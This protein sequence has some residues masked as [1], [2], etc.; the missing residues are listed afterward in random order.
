MTER[1]INDLKELQALPLNI[2]VAM[3]CSRIRSWVN[4]FG[5]DGV[6]ISFSGG[7]DSTVLMDLVRNVCGYK[8]RAMFVDVPTQYPELKEFVKTFPDVDIVKPK[9]SF[10]EVCKKYGF[11]LVSKEVSQVVEEARKAKQKGKL[12]EER[13]QKL[14]GEYIDPKTGELSPY[15]CPKWKFLLDA[16]FDVST[17]CCAAMKKEPAHRYTKETGRKRMTAMM[18]EES[19][20]RTSAWIKQGCNAFDANEPS[21]MPMAFWTENDVLEYIYTNKLPICSVY[22]EVIPKGGQLTFDIEGVGKY[23]TTG[24]KR[25]GCMLCGFGCHLEKSPNRFEML[26]ETHPSMHK[27]F[28]ACKNNGVTYREAIEWINE[29]GNLNIKI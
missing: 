15:N 3:S 29:H 8:V 20:R 28:D 6:Y 16:P 1:T 17:R 25:T 9:I 23:E 10:V 21:S 5:E 7:K 12:F 2:K 13:I 18:A 11:P 26:R 4:E 24:C 22:G 14:S 27:L 19:R